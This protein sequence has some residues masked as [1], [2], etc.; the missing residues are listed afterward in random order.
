VGGNNGRKKN[1]A[2]SA[3]CRTNFLC[4]H[5]MLAD[6]RLLVALE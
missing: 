6:G 5:A 2:P 4:G 3:A 1:K